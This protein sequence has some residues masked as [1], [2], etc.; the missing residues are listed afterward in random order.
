[1]YIEILLRI[2]IHTYV[3]LNEFYNCSDS[4]DETV[5]IPHHTKTLVPYPRNPHTP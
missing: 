3:R 2:L 5:D 1:M 4:E